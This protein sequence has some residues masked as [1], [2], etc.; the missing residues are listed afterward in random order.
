MVKYRIEVG[1]TH[2]VKPG[3]IVGAITSESGLRGSDIG[4]IDIN[5]NYTTVDLPAGLSEDLIRGLQ[6]LRVAG[7]PLRIREWKIRGGGNSKFDEK[8]RSFNRRKQGKPTWKK[9]S[10]KTCCKITKFIGTRERP[11]G[12][13]RS[14]LLSLVVAA[15]F[16]GPRPRKA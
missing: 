11:A 14:H 5:T 10:K 15:T 3:N 6:Q 13:G 7:Q 8:P 16:G 4:G 12:F 1:Y 9:G 2:G